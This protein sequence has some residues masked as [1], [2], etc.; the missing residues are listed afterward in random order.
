MKNNKVIICF[1]TLIIA[2]SVLSACDKIDETTPQNGI[3]ENVTPYTYVISI[4]YYDFET[5]ISSVNELKAFDA[6]HGGLFFSEY[7]KKY[8]S[9]SQL[10][11]KLNDYDDDF[12]KTKEII[13]AQRT[14]GHYEERTFKSLELIDDTFVITIEKP[15]YP[16]DVIFPE[17]ITSYVFI[18][19]VEKSLGKHSV[20]VNTVIEE[21][22][23]GI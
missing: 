6:E 19:E 5:V 1:F 22:G 4:D 8:Y 18:L 23:S 15:D 16:G 9:G 3:I 13:F 11:K 17:V 20:I 14:I 7:G 21:N 12:F 2:F 10:Y